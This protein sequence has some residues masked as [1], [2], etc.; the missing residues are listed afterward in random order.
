M[1]ELVETVGIGIVSYGSREVAMAKA[2]LS[3]TKYNVELY[4]ADRLRNIYNAKHAKEHVVIPTLDIK[5]I[6][7][8]FKRHR[9]RIDFGIVGPE[10][11][12]IQGIREEVEKETRIP[13]IC[14]TKEY[15]LERSKVAQRHLLGKVVPDANPR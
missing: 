5:E 9:D 7:A 12:I 6:G 2:F 3:S 14:P 10:D 8:F 13:L 11:P 1:N 4:I 15:A